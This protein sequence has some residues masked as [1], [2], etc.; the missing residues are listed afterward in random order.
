VFDVLAYVPLKYEDD[1]KHVPKTSWRAIC[2]VPIIGWVLH[3]TLVARKYKI[4]LKHLEA[5]QKAR[6]TIPDEAWDLDAAGLKVKDTFLDCSEYLYWP[7]TRFLPSDDFEA[8][9]KV[10]VDHY[11]KDI[12]IFL[13]VLE[14]S[15]NVSFHNRDI[16]RLRPMTLGGV[17]EYLYAMVSTEKS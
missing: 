12:A 15:L 4:Y 13:G 10:P 11:T 3:G 9:L 5:L 16:E 14:S 2:H 17:V 8:I 1:W 6:P 7:N